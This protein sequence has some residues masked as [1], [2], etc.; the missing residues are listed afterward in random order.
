MDISNPHYAMSS[1]GV[2]SDVG[3]HHIT[4]PNYTF[5]WQDWF[6]FRLAFGGGRHFVEEYLERFSKREDFAEFYR[7][8]QMTY[9]PTHAKGAVI[10]IIN[11]IFER[12]RD[13]V[14]LGGPDSYQKAINGHDKGV[15]LEGNT[16]DGYVGRVVLREMAV[17]GKVGVFVDKFPQVPGASLAQT[18]RNRP[19]LYHYKAEDI[20]SW[21]KNEYNELESLLLRDYVEK[22]DPMTGLVTGHTT[23]FRLLRRTFSEQL[24]RVVV[25]VQFFDKVGKAL[26]EE[27]AILDLPEIPFVHFGLS[28]SL[29][30]DVADYQI[31]LLNLESSDM[32]YALKSNFPLYVEQF[33]PAADLAGGV[34]T[35]PPRGP[36]PPVESNF[37]GLGNLDGGA[38]LGGAAVGH[39]ATFPDGGADNAQVA[40]NHTIEMGSGSGRRYPRGLNEPNFINPAPDP[41]RVSME[42]QDRIKDDIRKLVN[43][44]AQSVTANSAPQKRADDAGL[45]AG[46]AAIGMELEWGE[47]EIARIWSLYEGHDP[48]DLRIV[49][50]KNYSIMTE[51]ERQA[52]AERLGKIGPTIPSVTFKKTIA[53]RQAQIVVGHLVTNEQLEKIINEI[54]AA[55][56]VTTDPDVIAQDFEKGF[57]SLDTASQARGYA[58]GE[59]EKAKKDHA[60]RLARIAA[61]QSPVPTDIV[62]RPA[63]RGVP[64]ADG[65][66]DSSPK[67][68]KADSRDNTK[69]GTT[70][71]RT[72]GEGK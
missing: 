13:I 65:D 34:F 49:Y 31:A 5:M 43:L 45:L 24:G 60:E 55:D 61:A 19:F 72:R 42:K 40:G 51:E 8:K 71:D 16:M 17:I 22:K 66:P 37:V 50:P 58:K 38:I 11:S 32:S 53:K 48:K 25:L 10:D 4:H 62:D 9:A 12:M 7:R 63:A 67:D 33:D 2:N 59:V 47:R 26:E 28:E 18:R 23:K 41:I 3:V 54:E 20:R 68:E 69:R 27:T 30:T 44:T 46:L 35:R 57:V 15:D 39:G 36:N 52:E 1:P 29:L 21:A 70:E 14:R 6:K 56:V 64:D